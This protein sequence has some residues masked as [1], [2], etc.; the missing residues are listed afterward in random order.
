MQ[1]GIAL[2]NQVGDMTATLNRMVRWGEGYIGGSLPIAMTAPS[3]EAARR[4][5]READREGGP[6]L[7]ALTYFALSDPTRTSTTSPGSPTSSPDGAGRPRQAGL[8]DADLAG[9][10]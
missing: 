9:Y 2:P 4:A 8:Y 3:F 5:W 10:R 7:V 6:R 1:I